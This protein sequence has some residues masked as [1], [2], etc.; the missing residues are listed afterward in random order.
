MT[1]PSW[2]FAA[3]SF[4]YVITPLDAVSQIPT[5]LCDSGHKESRQPAA[6]VSVDIPQASDALQHRR[7]V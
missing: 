1:R 2:Q 6:G 3:G 5:T 4:H 7:L